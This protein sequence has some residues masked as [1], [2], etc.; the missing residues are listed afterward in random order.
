M[1]RASSSVILIIRKGQVDVLCLVPL[2]RLFSVEKASRRK[3]V[4]FRS[5][6]AL[7]RSGILFRLPPPLTRDNGTAQIG[8]QSCFAGFRPVIP[9][10][11]LPKQAIY[12][13]KGDGVGEIEGRNSSGCGDCI[14]STSES[15]FA[16]NLYRRTNILE[17][18]I[19]TVVIDMQRRL[20]GNAS[21]R[22]I[23]AHCA[24]P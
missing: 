22:F 2:F 17:G 3:R 6:Q 11:P 7:F 1:R 24:G 12:K 4:L 19:A 15:S 9:L 8:S 16:R 21:R 13:E 10:V 23:V 5:S 14:Q 18:L 20:L